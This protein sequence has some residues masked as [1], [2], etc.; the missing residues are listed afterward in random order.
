MVTNIVIYTGNFCCAERQTVLYYITT[1]T[2]GCLLGPPGDY[3]LNFKWF[4]MTQS[5]AK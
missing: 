1:L 3:D 5:I 4:H 2:N